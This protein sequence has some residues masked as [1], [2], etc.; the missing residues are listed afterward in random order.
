MNKREINA[1]LRGHDRKRNFI[2][3]ISEE[4]TAERGAKTGIGDALPK[5]EKKQAAS[6]GCGR[7]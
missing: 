1:G 4:D 5:S 6:D 7:F 3:N 2:L